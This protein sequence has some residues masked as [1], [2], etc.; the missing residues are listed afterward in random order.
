MEKSAAQ[1]MLVFLCALLILSG[2]SMAKVEGKRYPDAGIYAP[3]AY[4]SVAILR[5]SPSRSYQALG[6]I[7][8]L[9]NSDLSQ[10]TIFKKLKKAAAKMGADAVVLVAD[11]AGLTGGP[12]AA[13]QEWKGS[14][15]PVDARAIVGVAIWFP[16]PAW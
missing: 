8:L 5:S 13:L 12:V 4:K 7:H 14:S 3:V 10:K 6:E 9:S 16:R 2:C 15:K 1:F 11:P